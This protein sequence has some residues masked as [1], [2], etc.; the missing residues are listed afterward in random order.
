[1]NNA[2]SGLPTDAQGKTLVLSP[3]V[4]KAAPAAGKTGAIDWACCSTT[5]GTATARG[6]AN[7]AAGTL[8]AKYA[9]AEC[10]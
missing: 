9:P 3:N 4:Q 2:S 10:R 7:R 8:P 6:L 1:M 5:V